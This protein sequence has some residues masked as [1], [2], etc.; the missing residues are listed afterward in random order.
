MNRQR[1]LLGLVLLAS[2]VVVGAAYGTTFGSIVKKWID[3][4]AY[5]HGWLI[6]PISLWLAW[7]KRHALA[8]V[9][10]GPSWL[11]VIAALVCAAG[12][13]IARG[14]GVLVIEQFAVV[15]MIPAV[16]LAVLGRPATRVLIFPLAFLFFAVPFGRALV[17]WLMQFTADVSTLALRWTGIPILR[18]HMYI[19]I[20]AGSFEV[21]RACSGLNYL[22]TGLV[23]GVLYAYLTYRSWTKR[24]LCVAA[25]LVVPIMA[26]GLRVYFTILVSHLTEMRFGPGTEHVTFGRVFFILVMLAMFW[27]G[28]RWHDAPPA[29]EADMAAAAVPVTAL[30]ATAWAPIPLAVA[31]L[32][33]AQPYL[34]ASMERAAGKLAD[35]STL[36]ALPAA[37]AGWQG[38]V[39]GVAG[40]RPDYTGGLVEKSGVYQAGDNGE[41]DVF[42]S[43][44]ALGS[45]LGAEMVSYSNVL[46]AKEH[47]SLAAVSRR[48]IT[49]RDGNSVMVREVEVP[50]EDGA[51]LVWHW[52][53]VGDRAVTNEFAVKALEAAAFVTRGADSERV[54]TLATPLDDGARERLE[55]F[56]AAHA[57]CVA[58]GFAAQA[59]IR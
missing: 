17:P 6:A 11:G 56:V 2:L 42:V 21:A 1:R 54:V 41:V 36:A 59:C 26:N 23:L 40:W 58:A 15:A 20:P 28:R 49:L 19:S 45:S 57:E 9:A 24:A 18:S 12:W 33:L 16:V 32:L 7:H 37:S 14:A 47:G 48:E 43:V 55:S 34:A 50:A 38:P 10:L 22:V 39:E 25:F 3:D 29:A 8:G 51:R 44:Y 13:I 30:P 4:S 46:Y 52:Y 53:L 31:I 5:S 27:I 35:P